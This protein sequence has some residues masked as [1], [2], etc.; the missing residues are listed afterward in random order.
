MSVNFCT[1]AYKGKNQLQIH[2]VV[3]KTG[4]GVPLCVLQ[5]FQK[6]QKEVDKVR[7][8]IK[9]AVL[10]GD[11][12]CPSICCMSYYDSKDVYLMSIAATEIKWV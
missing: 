6:N 1:G 4:C 2:G 5:E 10:K 3:R 12:S 11:P 9:A 7:G 8:T